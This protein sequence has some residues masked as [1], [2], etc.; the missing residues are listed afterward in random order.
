MSTN[1]SPV[2]ETFTVQCYRGLDPITLM[3][4]IV[5][6]SQVSSTAQHLAMILA[7]GYYRTDGAAFPSADQLAKDMNASVRT[8][9]RAIKELRE[10]GE[11]VV[12]PGRG[13][14][15][16]IKRSHYNQYPSSLYYPQPPASQLPAHVKA[17]GAMRVTVTTYHR[18][19]PS[20]HLIPEEAVRD[21]DAEDHAAYWNAHV[22]A[23]AL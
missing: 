19:A 15:S 23:G 12:I 14:R 5:E 13:S 16:N 20:E 7:F 10:S 6:H 21:F 11:W 22:M 3:K 1:V 9:R 4:W 8:V 18:E 17:K 2:V